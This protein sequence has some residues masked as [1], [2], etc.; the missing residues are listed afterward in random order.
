MTIDLAKA[1]WQFADSLLAIS[2]PALG[3]VVEI[4][5]QLD[6]EPD[7]VGDVA[8]AAFDGVRN[9]RTRVQQHITSYDLAA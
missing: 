7:G 6:P 8:S 5:K 2:M 3:G 4:C 9:L 1:K